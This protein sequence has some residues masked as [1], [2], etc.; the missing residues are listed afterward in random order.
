MA[1]RGTDKAS[2][3]L[4]PPANDH[5]PHWRWSAVFDGETNWGAEG[6]WP[7]LEWPATLG[8]RTGARC[9]HR[10]QLIGYCGAGNFE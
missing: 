7:M 5:A 9:G 3:F 6:V 1:L 10:W 2:T 4:F 8:R